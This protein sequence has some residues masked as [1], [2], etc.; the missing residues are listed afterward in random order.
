ML[1]ILVVVSG[2]VGRVVMPTLAAVL[3]YAAPTSLLG[4]AVTRLDVYGSLYHAG[5]RT[6]AA[7]LP[8]TAGAARLAA[9]GGRPILSGATPELVEPERWVASGQQAPAR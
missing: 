1:A 4:H 7:R 9:V 2:I 8:D 6:L 5:A 3:I